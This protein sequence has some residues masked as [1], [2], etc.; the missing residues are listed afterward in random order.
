LWPMRIPKKRYLVWCH[1]KNPATLACANAP[2]LLAVCGAL[3]KS[4][5]YKGEQTT[6]LGDWFM[7]DCG[8]FTQTISLAAHKLG[9]GT[10]IV[11]LFDH[12]A[13]KKLLAVPDGYEVV[14]LLPLGYPDHAPSAPKRKAVGEFVHH[15]RF[16]L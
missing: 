1:Q 11:G 16:S 3:G 12:H 7:Y 9:L 5:F 13:V 15:E 10:V 6:I 4:G 2:L 14:A 8:L